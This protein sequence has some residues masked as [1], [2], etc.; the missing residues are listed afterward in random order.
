MD[1]GTLFFDNVDDISPLIYI[2]YW[3]YGS[4]IEIFKK[5][6]QNLHV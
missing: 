6:E 4:F 3:V 1:P 2:S 5:Y